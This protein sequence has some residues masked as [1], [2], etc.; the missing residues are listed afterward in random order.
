MSPLSSCG[1]RGSIPRGSK[2]GCAAAAGC[3]SDD[4]NMC[5][6]PIMA[7][8]DILEFVQSSKNIIDT[9]SD[10]ENETNNAAPVLTS[11][12][13]RNVMKSMRSYLDAHF[14]G[15]MNNKMNNIE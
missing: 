7:D 9:D 11:S 5:I 12:E 15:E 4:D 6:A 10:D 14:N 3:T 1:R 8:K 2:R 13:I